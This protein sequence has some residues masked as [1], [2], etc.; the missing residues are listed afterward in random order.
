MIC[1][2]RLEVEK[3][4]ACRSDCILYRGKEYKDLDKCPKCEAPLYKD[5]KNGSRTKGS[6]VKVAWYFPVLP[7]LERLFANAE[8][9]KLLR[10]HEEGHRKDKMLRHPA[11]G[12]DWRII[13]SLVK[14]NFGYYARNIRFGLSTDGMNPFD[15]VR[16]NHST[17]PVTLCIYNMPPWLCMKRAY[18]QLAV[19]IQGPRQPGND[20]DVY[21]EPL[22]DD[23]QK[24]WNEG[25]T[26]WDEYTKKHCLV[27]GM[28]LNTITN[29][30]GRGCL[31][32]EATKG[33]HGCVECL[34][35]LSPNGYRTA[36]RWF[37]WVIIGAYSGITLIAET[38]NHLTALKSIVNFQSIETGSRYLKRLANSKL[39]LGREKKKF[40]HLLV[41][42]GKKHQSSGNFLIGNT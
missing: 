3:I 29:L 9:A 27:K 2:L 10:W 18:L 26:V 39:P 35:R 32:G 12:S 33:Y 14:K 41:L 30:P 21:L 24:L 42:C 4:H 37:I 28:L 13:D 11:N 17:W 34:T 15:M 38:R 36:T 19:M 31:S 1:P 16:T 23:L 20:I 25:L 22:M 5:V 6:P 40:L 7:R 8:M